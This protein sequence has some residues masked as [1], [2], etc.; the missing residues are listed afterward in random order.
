[1]I[2]FVLV[3]MIFM[4]SPLAADESEFQTGWTPNSYKLV[5]NPADSCIHNESVHQKAEELMPEVVTGIRQL[6]F[7]APVYWGKRVGRDT[8]DDHIELYETSDFTIAA[9]R[10]RC[11]KLGYEQSIVKIGTQ[12]TQFDDRDYL[13]YYF[14]SH[15]L[16]HVIQNEQPFFDA[17]TC[18]RIPQW[19]KEG[20]ATA[21]GQATMRKRYPSV[22]PEKRDPRVARNFSGLRRYDKPLPDRKLEEDRTP[23]PA[24]ED[25]YRTSSFWRH[26]AEAHYQ[27]RYDFLKDYM[28]NREWHGDWVAWLRNNVELGTG[29]HL[30]MVFG[31]FLAD[32]AGWG[33]SG[34]PGMYYGRRKWLYETFTGCETLY[35]NKSEAAD[36]VDIDLKPLAGK[37]IE[38]Y[39]SA[40]G[41]NGLNE[42]ES[43]A[44]QVA[45]IIMSG[46]P[47][48]R[49]GLHLSMA[50]S[51]D[52]DRFHCAR[53]V[54]RKGRKGVGRCLFVPDDGKIRLNGGPVDARFW[55]VFAQEKGDPPERR[56]ESG[57]DKGELANLY[58]V[59]Y[60]PVS[61]SS[62]TTK[63]GGSDPITARFYFAL[64]VAKLEFNGQ[65]P[66]SSGPGKKRTVGSFAEGSDPQTTLPKQDIS[67]NRA[68]S[69]SLPGQFR[70]GTPSPPTPDGFV[71]G[72]LSNIV[73]SQQLWEGDTSVSDTASVSLIP[74][75]QTENNTYEPYPLSVGETG[76]FPVSMIGS[77]A[78]EALGALAPGSLEVEEFS[79]L[80]FRASYNGTLCRLKEMDPEKECPNPI[81]VSGQIVKAFAGTRLP[82]RHMVIERT[83]GTEMYRKANEQGLAEWSTRSSAAGSSGSGPP[84]PGSSGSSGGAIQDCACTCEEREATI[85]LGEELKSRLEAGEDIAAGEIMGLGRCNTA[86]QREY[87]VCEMEKNEKEKEARKASHPA[88]PTGECDCSCAALKNLESQTTEL[89]GRFQSG[90]QSAMQEMQKLGQCMS[91]C[92]V[93][94]MACA[95]SKKP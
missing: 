45:A 64:D 55:N 70:P 40:L 10:A 8:A 85:R 95:G 52:K 18:A 91:A 69:Y 25:A 27:G 50:A 15:E 9:T 80:A 48:S 87:M 22:A 68:N 28:K 72:K 94:L 76:N 75:R 11:L 12:F 89:L 73:V 57:E 6:K 5:C 4:T 31:G 78:G 34:Y 59:S 84:S 46:P 32:Y 47:S 79:D 24:N 61:V 1:M 81:P 23:W 93:E 60:T 36:Y 49:D 51:N 38:V 20:T 71:P 92:Q 21:V 41:E 26:L 13:L 86:C 44:V 67:G 54:K 82:G 42:G 29:A 14:M 43:A 74:A 63:H 16:F 3:L 90:D 33:D 17:E 53:E 19:I 37:C 35:L 66:A 83:P 65:K 58:T 7:D 2:A 56:Q 62:K 30:G 39:V 77:L 88:T